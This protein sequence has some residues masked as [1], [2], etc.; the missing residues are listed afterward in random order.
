[1]ATIWK[2]S[3]PKETLGLG[4]TIAMLTTIWLMAERKKEKEIEQI[5]DDE[6]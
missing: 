5:E 4:I 3:N 2:V 6:N 1:M